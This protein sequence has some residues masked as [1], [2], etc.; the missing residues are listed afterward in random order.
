MVNSDD[1]E[2]GREERKDSKEKQV[3]TKTPERRQAGHATS[4]NDFTKPLQ[5]P[6][7]VL[8]FD[9]STPAALLAPSDYDHLYIRAKDKTQNKPTLQVESDIPTV[10]IGP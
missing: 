7:G 10:L 6:V 9:S 1:N 5:T 2:A 8:R 4:H 3:K